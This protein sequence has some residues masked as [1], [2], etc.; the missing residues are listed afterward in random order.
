METPEKKAIKVS[1]RV[2]R[3]L[4]EKLLK[5]T[6]NKNT[7]LYSG[8]HNKEE[9]RPTYIGIYET[10][11]MAEHLE[12]FKKLVEKKD[13]TDKI[14]NEVFVKVYSQ[15]LKENGHLYCG[16]DLTIDML[17]KY[18]CILEEI[19]ASSISWEQGYEE[20]RLLNI[21]FD[22]KYRMMKGDKII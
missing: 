22:E 3:E 2:Y 17:E 5:D 1:L 21:K 10:R 15:F 18:Q 13:L 16:V 7:D 4:R 9:I 11:W 19:I 20:M 12:R 8:L 14:Y 6:I